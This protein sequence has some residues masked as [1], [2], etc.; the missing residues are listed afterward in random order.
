MKKEAMRVRFLPTKNIIYAC[1]ILR[2]TADR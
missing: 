2:I 1:E